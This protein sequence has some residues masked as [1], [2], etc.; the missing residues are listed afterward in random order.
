MKLLSHYCP[1]H[2]RRAFTL[3]EL[4]VVIAIIAILA[5]MLLPALSKA[6]QK[7]FATSCLSNA[8]QLMLCAIM[9]AGDNDDWVVNNESQGNA[10]CGANAW[11]NAGTAAGA[12][13]TGNARTDGTD[14]A[15]RN[16]VL[17]QYNQSVGIYKCP[18][19]RGIV[20]AGLN[21]LPRTR[22]YSIPTSMNWANS[23][24]YS[25]PYARASFKKFANMIRPAPSTAAFFL[26]E[27]ENGIDNNVI[28]IFAQDSSIYWNVPSSRHNNAGIIA[29][30]DGHSEIRRWQSRWIPAA[31]A[32]PD[33]GGGPVGVSFNAP[34]GGAAQDRDYAY[35]MT[36]V[37]PIN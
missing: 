2:F 27:A 13:W 12:S 30:A 37:P 1:R 32:I 33:S 5:A 28:G 22:S 15:L 8:K 21:R 24:D 31:N 36:L 26:E 25:N 29:F 3:I 6:K 18:A 20:A 11:I 23:G 35:L 9:Y 7:A 10:A 16:G 17:A 34:S 4:L 19:D 14:L